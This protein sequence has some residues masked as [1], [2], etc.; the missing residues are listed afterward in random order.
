MT[1]RER[2]S[3]PGMFLKRAYRTVQPLLPLL[4][5]SMLV[6]TAWQLGPDALWGKVLVSL[7]VF[8]VLA[9]F[10]W[11]RWDGDGPPP[12]PEEIKLRFRRE[13]AATGEWVR[14]V[15][16]VRAVEQGLPAG[17]HHLAFTDRTVTA[18]T[19]DRETDTCTRLWRA[20]RDTVTLEGKY[21][22]VAQGG[23]SE[24]RA[25]VPYVLR[26]D[27]EYWQQTG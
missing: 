4:A 23:E 1:V 2:G 6:Q 18:F 26:G 27:V 24:R 3:A 5:V 19:Y 7:G 13:T 25:L 22:V 10:L 14:L 21:L 8:A 20:D 12:D 9:L 17:G 11:W 15:I 16:P